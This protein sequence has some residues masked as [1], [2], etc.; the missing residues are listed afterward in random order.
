MNY[1]DEGTEQ[2]K[3][4]VKKNDRLK[5]ERAV[6]ETM[7]QEIAEHVFPRKAGVTQKDYTPNNQRDAYLYD[8]TAK[9]SLERAIAG[10]MTWTTDK[11]QPW[12]EFT[13]TL[14]HRNSEPVKNWL[15]EC[16]MLGAEYVANSNFYAE[17]HESLFDKWGFGTDCLFSQVTP[18]R[19][20]RF[21]K[22]RVGT[23]VFWTDWMGRAEGL[24]REFD[25]TASQA[26]GQFSR[27]N[28]PKCITD[29]LTNDT[30]KKFTFLHIVEPRPAKDRGDGTGYEVG[31]RKAFL[32]AYV[33]KTSCKIV[34]E[35]GFDSF[36]FT[37]GRFS[38][39]DA[40][41]DSTEWG[42]GP[43]FSLLPESR[44]LNFMSKMM[45]VY[46][47]KTV[48]P[49]LMVPDTYEGTLKTSAR[50]TNYYPAGVGADSIFP[51][52]V[53]GDWSVAMERLKMR[54]EMI[55]R[56]CHLDMFQMF[57]QNAA[58]NREMTAYE[59]SQLAGEKLEAISPAF[60]R[61][62]T[63]SISPHVIRCFE[64]WAEN[65]MLPPPPEEAIVQVGPS[66][67]QVPNPTVTM[68]NRLALALR[69]LTQR[70]ADDQVQMIMAVAPVYPAAAQ[71][72][73]WHY[74]FSERNRLKGSDPK[75][76]IPREQFDQAMQA[77][78][79]AAQAQQAAM[80]ANEMAGTV[81]NVGGVDKARE[82]VGG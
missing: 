37:V 11:S 61:D 66:L 69:A 14:Q 8:I 39:W 36:P 51:L 18:E 47:E 40:L 82:L 76:M 19:Q 73:D 57:A 27:E 60:D 38:H 62:T 53:T 52:Q 44:Q 45:D 75:L 2:T 35:G 30:G 9:D 33:E 63:E 64:G 21:E 46:S 55:K 31:K 12:F 54:Q 6:W 49:P 56:V 3:A 7:W 29:A 72:I 10:Y 78:A 80:M 23:Y 1:Q 41:G 26:E 74:Y 34:Q 32:S 70:G 81:K 13:P 65:G 48:F 79:Q 50:A 71:M 5:G 20:T 59:A 22:I 42:F 15:R 68:T 43:G 77:Q 16:S 25:L 58:A 28:L 17:R 4:W 24:I 67:I